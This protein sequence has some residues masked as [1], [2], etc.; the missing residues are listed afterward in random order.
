LG[1]DGRKFKIDQAEA[2]IGLPVGHIAHFRVFVANAIGFQFGEKL[3]RPGLVKVFHPASAIRRHNGQLPWVGI[4]Q[5][6]HEWTPPHFQI[7]QDFNF[8]GEPFLCFWTMEILVDLAIVTDPYRGPQSI[9]YHLHK[10]DYALPEEGGNH[11]PRS[12]WGVSLPC[13][14]KLACLLLK[15][16]T[17]PENGK[18]GNQT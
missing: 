11:R 17:L 1:Q 9:L 15:A 8:I 2:P 14:T 7:A 4:E 18:I 5:S 6:G 13:G 16:F 10:T 3:A 12:V